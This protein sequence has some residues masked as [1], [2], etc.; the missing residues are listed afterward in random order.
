MAFQPVYME[1][2]AVFPCDIIAASSFKETVFGE[3]ICL[4]RQCSLRFIIDI[5]DLVTHYFRQGFGDSHAVYMHSCGVRLHDGSPGINVN[6]QPRQI[7]SLTVYKTVGV[8]GGI[9]CDTDSTTHIIGNLQFT[10][11]EIVVDGFLTER[12]HTYGDT[13]DLEMSFGYKFLLRSVYFYNFTFFGFSIETSDCSGEN[14]GM[15]SF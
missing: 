2:Q 4:K 14:P 12:E 8:I 5:F 13:S 11:P 9:D 6:D 10:F 3:K 1:L 7:V 15:K